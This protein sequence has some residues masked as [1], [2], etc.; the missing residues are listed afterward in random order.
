M[1]LIALVAAA[2]AAVWGAVTQAID[3][4]H[5]AEVDVTAERAVQFDPDA[6]CDMATVHLL[7]GRHPEVTQFVVMATDGW[8]D[9][10]GT[11]EVAARTDDGVG[12]SWASAKPIRQY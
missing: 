11:V 6:T 12:G 2:V 4:G 9:T 8:D 3:G 10:T 5:V 7:A 1:R